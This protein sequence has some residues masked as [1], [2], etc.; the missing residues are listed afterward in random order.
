MAN[1]K[2]IR[3][4]AG[5]VALV[6]V[7]GGSLTAQRASPVRLVSTSPS[8]TET[9][10]ALGLGDRVVGVSSYCRFP[11]EVAALPKVGAFL[12]PD[13]EVIARLKPDLVFV[14]TGPNTA[15][16]QLAALRIPTAMI[17]RG[18][19]PTIFLTI[20]QIGAAAGVP[21]RGDTLIATITGRLDRVKTAVAGRTPRTV[22]IIVGRQTGTLSDLIAVGHSSYL[23]E[24]AAIAG[25][26]NALPAS[27]RL[28]YPR[29]SMETVISLSPDVI[30]DIGEMGESPS[31]S[32]R[33]R[34]ITESLWKRQ[35]LVEAAH[36][37]RVFVT[38]DE[39]FTVPGP[40]IVNVAETMAGWFHGVRFP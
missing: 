5:L 27:V 13:A 1:E 19:L 35:T 23:N 15:A 10:F 20:R 11:P 26:R 17:D 14:H 29:I 7:A 30:V 3:R 12:S 9:L 38:T 36:E 24:V 4:R 37:G 40:R 16:A 39:A 8:I 22:L 2:A 34:Q 31:D 25:G 33:R 28:E 6:M 32:D 18:S 21:D